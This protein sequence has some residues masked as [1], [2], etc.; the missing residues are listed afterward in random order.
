MAMN[1]KEMQTD[2]I[3]Y[4]V[5]RF[6]LVMYA[7]GLI[8]PLGLQRASWSAFVGMIF[9]TWIFLNY[10]DGIDKNTYDL[11]QRKYTIIFTLIILI[12]LL[13]GG[14]L[15]MPGE[16]GDNFYSRSITCN[17][18]DDYTYISKLLAC[19]Q[20]RNLARKNKG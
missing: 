7:V 19:K 14:K 17:T 2:N 9:F 11:Y 20:G 4:K 16:R 3:I 8:G 15:Y 18:W 10:T 13:G 12:L 1:V 6:L 5:G